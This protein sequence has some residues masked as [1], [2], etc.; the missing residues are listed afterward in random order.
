MSTFFIDMFKKM[1]ILRLQRTDSVDI[2]YKYT[3]VIQ[4]LIE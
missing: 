1:D 2:I 3:Y 4:R